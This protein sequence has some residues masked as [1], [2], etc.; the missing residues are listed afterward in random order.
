MRKIAGVGGCKGGR[1]RVAGG[2]SD[3]V[4]ALLAAVV[5]V[6]LAACSAPPLTLDGG[7]ESAKGWD[8]QDLHRVWT[9]GSQLY[10]DFESIASGEATF[11]SA[12]LVEGW[13]AE[14]ERIFKPLKEDLDGRRAHWNG[15]LANHECVML[16][17][18]TQQR[19]WNDLALGNS[20]WKAYLTTNEGTRVSSTHATP[21]KLK[22][23]TNR[24][25]FP[26]VRVFYDGY[27]LCFPKMQSGTKVLGSGVTGFEVELSSTL[28]R[29][30]FK[31]QLDARG[32]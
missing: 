17:L 23:P 24:H 12:S 15:L 4:R 22:D 7:N 19:E 31:W 8:Y 10:R 6:G 16:A 26:Q 28:G 32:R 11:L 5:F 18:T 3:L 20:M 2:A 9:R 30:A 21:M 29:L 13:L 14:Y 25:F 1:F 27:T